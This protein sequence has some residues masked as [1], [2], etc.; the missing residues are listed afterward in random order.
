[1][2]RTGAR[3]LVGAA[4][5]LAL[6]SARVAAQGTTSWWPRTATVLLAGGGLRGK[7]ADDLA[8]RL[9]AL[10]GGPQAHIVIIP[11]AN[12]TFD[13]ND[14]RFY[15]D[16]LGARH[17]TILHAKDRT[18]ANS[19][20]L[21]HI[22]RSA[23]AVFMTGGKFQILETTY[24][25]TLIQRELQAVLDRGGVLAGDAEGATAIGCVW[26]STTDD[27]Y[28]KRGD[29]LCLLPQVAVSTHV[30]RAQGFSI[31]EEVLKYASAHAGTIGIDIDENTVLIVTKSTAEVI[32]MGNV[33][34]IDAAR[35]AKQPYLRLSTGQRHDLAR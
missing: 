8:L 10:A 1:M 5:A 35:D 12:P 20:E 23:N 33:S 32:G 25:G 27:G 29:D 28:D 15:F 26:L 2:N 24:R 7:T 14:L 3:S 4:L 16:S 17:V 21:A 13:A 18:E 31:D 30:N 11:T 6:V 34:F 19:E 9:I 22:V